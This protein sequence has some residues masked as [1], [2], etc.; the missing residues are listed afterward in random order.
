MIIPEDF[1]LNLLSRV[2]LVSLINEYVPLK[3]SGANYVGL[4]PFHKEKT[5][6]FTISGIKQMYHCFGCGVH[7][8]AIS[9]VREYEG[10]GFIEAIE[11]LAAREGMDMPQS[12]SSDTSDEHRAERQAR[13]V[14]V[15]RNA[16]LAAYFQKQLAHHPEALNYAKKRGIHASEIKQYGIGFAPNTSYLQ[17]VFAESLFPALAVGGLANEKEGRFF[18][19]FR[20]RLM[21]PIRDNEGLVIAFGGR[22]LTDD[23]KP[24]YLNSPE[25]SLFHKSELVY[26]LYEGKK[27]IRENKRVIVVEGY[28]DV[29][30]LVSHGFQEAVAT[31]GTSVSALH[32]RKLFR[33]TERIY[34]CF[35]GDEAGRKAA[36]R[37]L[38]EALTEL[39][40]SR[41]IYF[42]FLPEGE[43]PDSY[44][45]KVGE[46][47]FT[48]FLQHESQALSHY[49]FTHLSSEVS[50]HSAEG[51]A[52]LLQEALPLLKSLKALSLRLLLLQ[53]LS[54]IVGIDMGQLQHLLGETP[55]LAVKTDYRPA[56]QKLSKRPKLLEIVPKVRQLIYLLLT[57][58]HLAS[59]VKLADYLEYDLETECLFLLAEG[60]RDK[61]IRHAGQAY[62]LLR[63][64]PIYGPLIEEIYQRLGNDEAN[65]L[66]IGDKSI[67]NEENFKR[68]LE[69][70]Q[71]SLWQQ[72][73]DE[74]LGLKDKSPQHMLLLKEL[75]AQAFRG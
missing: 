69:D 29:I 67:N 16:L 26:G 6:S 68:A 73:I 22:A 23:E 58:P 42:C 71:K 46:K 56:H 48:D 8:D 9:F 11:K 31:M 35:D 75:V 33:H 64:D 27:A 24:K 52:H 28:I 38:K 63:D 12:F 55:A 70:L 5:P 47:G 17:E 13:V 1:K 32:I 2:D 54:E 57:N 3:K 49:F 65:I 20:N 19:R 44:I 18:P 25:T 14:L 74:L 34:F 53:E 7:G 21:F 30:S 37:A 15:E 10:L 59:C 60:I 39:K 66:T 36:W 41:E 62:S 51:K 40:D 45:K 61:N 4:C 72:Q 50:L 43:D